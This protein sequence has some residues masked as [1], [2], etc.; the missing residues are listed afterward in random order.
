[1]SALLRLTDEER[2]VLATLH[3]ACAQAA[4]HAR[5]SLLMR[6]AVLL[7]ELERGDID[8]ARA[9]LESVARLATEETWR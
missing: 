6:L 2:L 1:M 5:S 9:A 8:D 3:G 7:D 4:T